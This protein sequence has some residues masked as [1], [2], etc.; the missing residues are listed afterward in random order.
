MI[1][2]ERTRDFALIRSLIASDARVYDAASDDGCPAACAFAPNRHPAIWYVLAREGGEL[3][4]MFTL[5]PQNACCWE[6]HMG[7][8]FGAPGRALGEIPRWAFQTIPGCRRIVASLRV[9][10][11]VAIR[12]AKRAGFVEY[13]RNPRSLLKGGQLLDQILLGVSAGQ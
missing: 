8:V 1:R 6:I 9:T 12:A 2:F 11:R 13:G 4:G 7:R 5:I 10:N 3:A